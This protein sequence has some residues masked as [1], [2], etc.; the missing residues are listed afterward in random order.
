MKD[1][2]KNTYCMI[3]ISWFYGWVVVWLLE[4]EIGRGLFGFKV[5]LSMERDL[6]ILGVG[7]VFV[8]WGLGWFRLDVDVWLGRWDALLMK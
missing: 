1:V 4:V 5:G 2:F 6:W 3:W 7:D 8:G